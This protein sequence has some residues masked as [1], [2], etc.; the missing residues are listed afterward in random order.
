MQQNSLE[1]IME[2]IKKTGDRFVV[3]DNDSSSAFVI[4]SLREYQ[5][6]ALDQNEVKDLTEEE[7]LNK[8]NRDIA[9]WKSSQEENLLGDE[10]VSFID[11][12]EDLSEDKYYF[13]PLEE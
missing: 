10:P 11:D 1:Q 12:L 13:E 9:V 6:L 3:L 8:I 4:L 2:L 5:R 7:L